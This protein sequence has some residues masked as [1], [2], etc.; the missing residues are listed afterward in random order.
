VPL[1]AVDI[2]PLEKFGWNKPL[3]NRY[4]SGCIIFPVELMR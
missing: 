4:G 3:D 2:N 1:T